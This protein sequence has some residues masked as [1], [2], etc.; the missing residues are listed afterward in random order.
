MRICIFGTGAVG[1]YFGGRLAAASESVT[2]IARGRTLDALCKR[3]LR[4]ESPG[5]DLELDDIEAKDDP[6]AVGEVDAVIVGVKAWQVSGA[7]ETMTP[8]IGEETV[9]LPLQ[10]GI[11]ASAQLAA[12]LGRSHALHGM[13]R[14]VAQQVEPGLIRHEAVEPFIALGDED[15]RARERTKRL[16]G[17]L[18]NAGIKVKIP[19]DIRSSVWQKYLFIAPVSGLGA[20]K[21]VPV[22]RLRSDP[23]T[24]RLLLAAM[25]E[26]AG[27]AEARG[28]RLPVGAVERTMAFLD[29]MPADATSSMQRD[30]MDGRPS[31]LEAING[32]AVRIGLETG[33]DTPVNR[34]IYS[35]LAPLE[36]IHRGAKN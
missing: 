31:E 13:C 9:V 15:N 17:A 27:L 28:V 8:L 33:V 3:G 36:R 5:G 24:R 35:T 7:A 21:L 25:W 20:V 32:A 26:I 22:G 11:E 16:A 1:G 19:R 23:E 6:A 4:I 10:N 29:G 12:V 30:I 14:I 34:F 18:E 2:F